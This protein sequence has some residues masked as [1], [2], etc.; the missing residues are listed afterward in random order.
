MG[1]GASSCMGCHRKAGKYRVNDPRRAREGRASSDFGIVN[2]KLCFLYDQCQPPPL[3]KDDGAAVDEVDSAPM[4]ENETNE[5][6]EKEIACHNHCSLP[7][8][9]DNS[10]IPHP[11]LPK[12]VTCI[13]CAA[14]I[15][16]KGLEQGMVRKKQI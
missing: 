4:E 2:G 10:G 5:A 13:T 12:G 15:M 8:G 3:T 6:L 7:P 9:E 11:D 16:E 1:I 14:T